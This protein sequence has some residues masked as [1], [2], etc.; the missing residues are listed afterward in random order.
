M[1]NSSSN[2]LKDDNNDNL[3][4][5]IQPDI[6]DIRDYIFKLPENQIVEFSESYKINLYDNIKLEVNNSLINNICFIIYNQIKNMND[7]I[8]LIY[9]SAKYLE[10]IVNSNI[11]YQNLSMRNIF[12]LINQFGILPESIV[13]KHILV[14]K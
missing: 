12:K 3:I 14:F 6:L 8:E 9:P 4:L 10:Y 11:D 1:G 7:N 2:E 5:N 13:D